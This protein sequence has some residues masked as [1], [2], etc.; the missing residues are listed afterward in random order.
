MQLLHNGCL[1]C[2][3]IIHYWLPAQRKERD[4]WQLK[5]FVTHG[6]GSSPTP[7]TP[8]LLWLD[9]CGRM[10]ETKAWSVSSLGWHTTNK[11]IHIS[12]RHIKACHLE[13]TQ[14]NMTIWTSN[15]NK[16]QQN[17]AAEKNKTTTKQKSSNNNNKQC[18]SCTILQENCSIH[19]NPGSKN[20]STE[21]ELSDHSRHCKKLK[22][23]DWYFSLWCN[24]PWHNYTFWNMAFVSTKAIFLLLIYPKHCIKSGTM[25]L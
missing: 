1:T 11:Q 15:N 3:F 20:I 23:Q 7:P 24:E 9:H 6:N 22:D 13:E 8:Q 25:A 12:L 16:Q 10:L 19:P 2:L 17:T 18:C 5:A 14:T 4:D 21:S